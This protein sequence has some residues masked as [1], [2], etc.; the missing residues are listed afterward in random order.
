[1][2][3][4]FT[5]SITIMHAGVG[6]H[7]VVAVP[8]TTDEPRVVFVRDASCL[9]AIFALRASIKI[10]EHDGCAIYDE[11]VDKKVNHGLFTFRK[12]LDDHA[13][14]GVWWVEGR[15]YGRQHIIAVPFSQTAQEI[16]HDRPETTVNA[17]ERKNFPSVPDTGCSRQHADE[18][19]NADAGAHH[20]D[21]PILVDVKK[22]TTRR[23][24]D[25]PSSRQS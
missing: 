6:D 3:R 17:L 18:G 19:G 2:E 15:R 16:S 5:L 20:D 24:P 11:I 14:G 10:D 12:T 13:K 7:D 8:A 4:R 25:I 23:P 22:E 9:R 1:M 21:R